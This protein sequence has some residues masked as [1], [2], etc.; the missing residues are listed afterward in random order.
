MSKYKSKTRRRTYWTRER[1]IEGMKIF[2][3]DFGFCPTDQGKWAKHQ[4]HTGRDPNGNPSNRGWHQKYPSYASIF[5]F[6]ASMRDAWRAA[7]FEVDHGFEEWSAIEDWFIIESAGILP[8]TEVAEILKRSVVAIKRRLYDLGRITCNNRWGVSVSRAANLVGVSESTLRKYLDRGIIP[9]FHGNRCIYINPADMPKIEEIDWASPDIDPKLDD[10]IRRSIA[11]RIAKILKFGAS[12]RDHEIY[13]VQK[14]PGVGERYKSVRVPSLIKDPP[15]PVPNDLKKGDWCR[16]NRVTV[17][18]VAG[19]IGLIKAVHYSPQLGQRRDNTYRKCWI[20]RV[21]FP[22]LRRSEHHNED[23]I[24]YSFPLDCLDRAD[25]PEIEVK[26]LSMNPEAIRG[27]QRFT[28]ATAC[29]KIGN[30]VSSEQFLRNAKYR[31]MP[32][33]R[34]GHRVKVGP[35]IGTIVGHNS[36]ANFNVLFDTDSPKY[37]GLKLNVHPSEI[38]LLEVSQ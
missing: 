15:P 33:L 11:Q 31:G 24:H 35:G 30:P 20:A 34:C 10:L 6:F 27:R 9:Y 22:R 19:R 3:R 7:G 14:K 17:V 1:V 36:S 37:A 32:D 5:N 12:W 38:V 2:Y 8:R 4:Q 25:K 13:K 23:R 28:T 26:P 29:R 21:E 18:G 16:V